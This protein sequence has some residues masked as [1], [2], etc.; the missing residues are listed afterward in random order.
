M[1]SASGSWKYN[2]ME[3]QQRSK[4]REF[5]PEKIQSTKLNI[6][7]NIFDIAEKFWETFKF[8]NVDEIPEYVDSKYQKQKEKLPEDIITKLK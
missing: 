2:K 1:E 4:N 6:V 5:S 8:G 3:L 7:E